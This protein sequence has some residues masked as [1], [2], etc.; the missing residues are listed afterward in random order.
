[1]LV[2]MCVGG[3]ITSSVKFNIEPHLKCFVSPLLLNVSLD[4]SFPS[5]VFIFL[6]K[7]KTTELSLLSMDIIM[8]AYI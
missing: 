6:S 1:M 3:H 5:Q 7:I 4:S 8:M 2:I